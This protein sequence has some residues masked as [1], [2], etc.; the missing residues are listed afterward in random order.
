MGEA[1]KNGTQQIRAMSK[2][3]LCE[4]YKVS[5]DTLRK[6]LKK[7]GGLPGDSRQKIFT[8]AQVKQIYENIG[9]P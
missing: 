8:P 2:K 6:W 1:I 3:E 9:E 5:S 4:K 7:W